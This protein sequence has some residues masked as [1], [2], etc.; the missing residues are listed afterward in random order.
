[1]LGISAMIRPLPFD[2]LNNTDILMVIFASSMLL[3]VLAV[4]KK[5]TI[6]R[7]KGIMFLLVYIAYLV[8]LVYRG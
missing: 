5:Y 2:V 1:V 6:T 8:Y 3:L 7:W 4:G